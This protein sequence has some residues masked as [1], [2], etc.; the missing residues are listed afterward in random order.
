M[1]H[2][3]YKYEMNFSW[4]AGVSGF[5]V[6][7]LISASLLWSLIF[8]WVAGA[9]VRRCLISALPKTAKPAHCCLLLPPAEVLADSGL[10]GDWDDFMLA[11]LPLFI[12]P[13][14]SPNDLAGEQTF[15]G[16]VK[17]CMDRT[18]CWDTNWIQSS[19]PGP[20]PWLTVTLL[21]SLD[22]QVSVLG[23]VRA[24]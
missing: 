3:T 16:A 8:L 19:T 9:R 17:S 10:Q 24:L 1:K 18:L 11:K 6:L 5:P 2:K 22:L 23:Q 15:Y 12:N 7:S 21:K 14:Q 4:T 13:S 20:S